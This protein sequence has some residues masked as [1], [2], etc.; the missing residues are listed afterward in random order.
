MMLRYR[1]IGHQTVSRNNEGTTAIEFAMVAPVLLLMIMGIVEYSLMMFTLSVMEAATSYSAR[2]G[3]TGYTASGSTRVEQ[4]TN[5]I[6]SRTGGMLDPQL[7]DID[8]L[9][10]KGF[11]KVGQSEPYTDTNGNHT[12][13]M[14]EPYTDSNGNGQWDI[15]IGI[16]G[17]GSGGDVVM[18]KVSYPWPIMTPLAQ[19]IIGNSIVLTTRMVVRNE[20]F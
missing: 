7:L 5:N 19:A 17:L 9:V 16:V 8:T 12:Y 15:D 10:Y 2:Y 13:N 14:G 3:K 1:R 11:D 6:I 18:Y 4:I 20:P